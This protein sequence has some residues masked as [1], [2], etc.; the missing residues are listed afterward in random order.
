MQCCT[1]HTDDQL[2]AVTRDALYCRPTSTLSSAAM[3]QPIDVINACNVY[4]KFVINAFVIFVNVDYF[5]KRHINV[6]KSFVE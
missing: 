3:R 5:N 1:I 2:L 6:E 4:Q